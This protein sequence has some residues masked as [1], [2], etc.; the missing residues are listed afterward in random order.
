MQSKTV[1]F[2]KSTKL[3][4]LTG[5]SFVCLRHSINPPKHIAQK[6]LKKMQ[7]TSRNKNIQES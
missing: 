4:L 3:L 6:Y 7:N 1:Y 5:S 2:N